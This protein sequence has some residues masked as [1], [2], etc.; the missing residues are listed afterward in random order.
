METERIIPQTVLCEFKTSDEN[1]LGLVIGNLSIISCLGLYLI[2]IYMFYS[3]IHLFP[4]KER[5]PRLALFQMIAFTMIVMLVYSVEV[6][7]ILGFDWQ[8]IDEASIKISRR[9]FK[10]LYM[11]LS[12]LTYLMYLPRYIILIC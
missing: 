1:I 6:L 9:F 5:A 11:S 3:R 10:A 7:Q 2:C 8:S 4:V 12:L